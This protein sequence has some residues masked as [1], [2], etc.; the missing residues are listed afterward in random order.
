MLLEGETNWKKKILRK[1]ENKRIGKNVYQANIN[2]RKFD[3]F[4]YSLHGA[5]RQK[6][7]PW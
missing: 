6:L 2:Q 7:T 4:L 5:E 1:I 3:I